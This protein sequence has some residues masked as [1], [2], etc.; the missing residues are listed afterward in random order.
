[1]SLKDASEYEFEEHFDKAKMI[2]LAEAL[3]KALE[4]EGLT[5]NLWAME[6]WRVT[7]DVRTARSSMEGAIH[8][9]YK[10]PEVM[11]VSMGVEPNTKLVLMHIALSARWF[12]E[13]ERKNGKA[14]QR[15]HPESEG[16]ALA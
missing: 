1:M 13:E 10:L 4:T 5:A 11:M 2:A 3:K 15:K 8:A 7:F 9:I 6:P 14:S 16:G 12:I